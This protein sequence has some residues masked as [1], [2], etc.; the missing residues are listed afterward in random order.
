MCHG[1]VGDTWNDE[2]HVSHHK[3]GDQFE[4]GKNSGEK[5]RENEMEERKGNGGKKR[6][7]REKEMEEI[8]SSEEKRKREKKEGKERKKEKGAKEGDEGDRWFLPSIHDVPKVRIR[9]TKEQSPSTR[10]GLRSKR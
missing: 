7:E 5:E 10:R 4:W 3:E 2:S 8:S 6:R 1:H 9:R